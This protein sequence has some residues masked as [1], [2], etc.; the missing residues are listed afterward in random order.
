M[1]QTRIE[2]YGMTI[3]QLPKGKLNKISDVIGV[4]VGHYTV[5]DKEH[6]TGV[7]V[8]MPCTDNP[9][10][11]KI[12]AAM[13][14]ING[15]GKTTGLMQIEELGVLESPIYLTNTLNVGKVFDAA[16]THM[17]KTCERE[18]IKLSTYNPVICE[19]N[20]A[21]LNAITER[22]VDE[23][24]VLKAIDAATLDFEE[25]AIGAGRGMSC[26][27]LKCGIGSASRLVSLL[28]HTYT[29]GVMVL[30]NHGTL[31][32]FTF[33][34]RHVGPLLKAHIEGEAEP[35]KGSIIVVVATDL[36]LSERQ[37]KRL[38]KRVPIGLAKTGSYIG[39]GSGE[40]AIGFTT[41]NRIPSDGFIQIKTLP[42][43]LLDVPFHAVAEAVEESVLNSLITAES[44]VGVEGHQRKSLQDFIHFII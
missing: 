24:M 7:T 3:G 38:L 14:V 16:V 19:C 23:A 6:Q 26:H 9:Y 18:N 12:T 15:F 1:N 42:D 17:V 5:N 28:D 33:S 27:H 29:V 22:V 10:L 43:D 13:H 8:V 35:E 40:V 20:D 39:H 21:Y 30:S 37:L 32:D 2:A 4:T 11:K 34:G 25:G 31:N 44:V 41:A 36:P